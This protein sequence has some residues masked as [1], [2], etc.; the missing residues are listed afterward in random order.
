MTS[1]VIFVILLR[2]RSDFCDLLVL[3][4]VSFVNILW[5]IIVI[6]LENVPYFPSDMP[7]NTNH[8]SRLQSLQYFVPNALITA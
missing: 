4:F 7:F 6:L 5:N 1:N 8:F 3:I 2:L